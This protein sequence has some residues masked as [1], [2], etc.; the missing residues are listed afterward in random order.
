MSKVIFRFIRGRLRPLRI[1]SAKAFADETLIASANARKKLIKFIATRNAARVAVQ[2]PAKIAFH[3]TTSEAAKKIYKEGFSL[4]FQK[5]VLSDH[6]VPN[7]VFLK[8]YKDAIGV[9]KKE[10]RKQVMVLNNSTRPAIFSD[11]NALMRSAKSNPAIRKLDQYI[12][13]HER[14]QSAKFDKL[15]KA[16][17]KFDRHDIRTAK[18]NKILY[19][20]R[21]V[22]KRAAKQSRD[23]ITEHFRGRGYDSVHIKHDA[24]SWSRKANTIAVMDPNKVTPLRMTLN[25]LKKLGAKK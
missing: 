14:V 25:R 21:E 10:G 19:R 24:G 7:A 22:S 8:P 18:L 9:A 17:E 12:F 5:A 2:S 3:E 4:N 15:W 16:R 1:K 6:E 23:F 11:R 13:K 20:W